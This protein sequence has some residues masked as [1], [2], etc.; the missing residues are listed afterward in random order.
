MAALLGAV[1]AALAQVFIRK[2]IKTEATAAI[3]FYFSATAS[4]LSLVTLPFGW[5]LP[6][7]R[8]RPRSSS[9]P[10]CSAASAR[11]C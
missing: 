11:S 1:C 4:L 7:A 9:A 3:V 10:A 6:D 2:L 5:A 8:A